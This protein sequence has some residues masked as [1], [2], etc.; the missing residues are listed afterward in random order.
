MSIL[1]GRSGKGPGGPAGGGSDVLTVTER[2]FEEVVIRSELPVMIEFITGSSAAAKQIASEVEGFAREMRGK[3]LTVKVDVEKAP[4]LARELRVQ[5]VPTFMVFAGQ[6]IV[7]VQVGAIRKKKMMEMVEPYLPRSEG[8]IKP[9][10][11]AQLIKEGQVVAVDTRDAGAFTRAHIPKASHLALEEIETRLA[12]LAMISERPVL[13]C[14]SGD[15][16]KELAA[17]LADSG[18]PVAYL[19]GGLLGW[20]GEGLPIERG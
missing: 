3:V 10:E 2:D 14:R 19:E 15:K 13:Y 20:E 18:M 8:A 12:E 5:Q 1:G 6:R 4:V 7:D 17:R 11:L 9:L 16:T